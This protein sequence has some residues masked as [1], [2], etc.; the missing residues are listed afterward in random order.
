MAYLKPF[1]GQKLFQILLID[2]FRFSLKSG[3]IKAVK[4]SET[5]QQGICQHGNRE[6]NVNIVVVI[7]NNWFLSNTIDVVLYVL[8]W[9][10]QKT[11]FRRFHDI[12]R[13]A[14]LIAKWGLFCSSYTESKYRRYPGTSVCYVG[15]SKIKNNWV[16]DIF[17]S[18]TEAFSSF[19]FSTKR[20]SLLWFY[21]PLVNTQSLILKLQYQSAATLAFDFSKSKPLDISRSTKEFPV[22]IIRIA[23]IALRCWLP[24]Y[25]CCASWFL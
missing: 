5:L 14:C 19:T 13:P 2:N 25:H 22:I 16:S 8:R 7:F 12:K 3:I 21:L 23:F 6:F 10:S 24:R 20:S 18:A 1:T 9:I 17:M 4:G 15:A 11:Y